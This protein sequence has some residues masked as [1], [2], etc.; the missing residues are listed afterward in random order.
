M[1]PQVQKRHPRHCLSFLQGVVALGAAATVA[2]AEPLARSMVLPLGDPTNWQLLQY[3]RLP[4][5]RVRFASAGLEIAVE[6]SAMPL[7]HVLPGRLR[8][9]SIRVKGRVEGALRLPAGRQGEKKYDDYVF[10]VGLVEPGTRTLNFVQRPLAAAW[11][12]KLFELAPK[13]SGI[14]GIHF[15]APLDTLAVWL[16]SDGDDTGSTF[17]VLVEEIELRAAP[18]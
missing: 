15:F 14:S 3:S 11:V 5:H 17:A 16:S 1:K 8:V 7:I 6:G 13:G 10:R 4:P 2:N 18:H 12:R 9:G